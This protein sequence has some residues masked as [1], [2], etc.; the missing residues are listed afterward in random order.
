MVEYL[1]YNFVEVLIW[2]LVF[3]FVIATILH[4]KNKKNR[5]RFS[6]YVNYFA[7]KFGIVRRMS[8][9]S[10]S[11]TH[12]KE[13]NEPLV[14]IVKHPKIFHNDDTLEHPVFLRKTV[15]MKLYKIADSL[16]D[17][18]YL[19]IYSTFRSRISVYNTWK[20]EEERLTKENP[21]MSRAA[22]LELVNAKVS[23]PNVNMG[24]HDTGAAIDLALCDE[25]KNDFDFG[26]KYQEKNQKLNLTQEQKENRKMLRHLMKS[27]KFVNTPDRWWHFSYGDRTWAAYRCKRNGAFYGAVEKEF[28]NIGYVR[29]VKT[30]I[31][32]VNIK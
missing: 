12:V 8:R 28:E 20:Q 15:A 17:N 19:K 21:N 3:A 14:E 11:R 32:S 7:Y 18:V 16:P 6:Y 31:K 1:K 24:G 25:N 10:I 9:S 26:T 27:Q 30:E 4:F 29:V 13:C 2:V 23:S 22:L 5:Q